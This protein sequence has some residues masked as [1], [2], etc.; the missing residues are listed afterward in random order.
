MIVQYCSVCIKGQ[1]PSFIIPVSNVLT[2]DI[3]ELNAV[4]NVIKIRKFV[5]ICL[6]LYTDFHINYGHPITY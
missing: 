5:R 2:F 1:N 3:K 6:I 4:Y